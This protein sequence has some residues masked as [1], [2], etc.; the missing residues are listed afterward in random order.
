LMQQ[1]LRKSQA[2][3]WICRGFSRILDAQE[4]GTDRAKNRSI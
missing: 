1:G 3:P 4:I 2:Y